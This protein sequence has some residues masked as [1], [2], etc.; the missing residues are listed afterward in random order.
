MLDQIQS[1]L[2]RLGLLLRDEAQ[3]MTEY[4]LAVSVIAFG[5]VAGM[6]ALATGLNHTF[7]TIATTLSTHLH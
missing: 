4:A 3:N 5:T 6:D 7:T 2:S 1:Y